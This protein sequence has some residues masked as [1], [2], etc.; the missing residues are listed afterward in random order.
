MN[1]RVAETEPESCLARSGSAASA[2]AAAR[3]R[4]AARH[5]S[6]RVAGREGSRTEP[7]HKDQ[8]VAVN[9]DFS[10]CTVHS[11]KGYDAPVV[12]V[13]SA[14]RFR[15]GARG[16]AAFYVACTRAQQYLEVCTGGQP[17][18]LVDELEHGVERLQS[19][20]EQSK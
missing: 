11:A 18:P 8:F 15:P 17:A 1:P 7:R 3:F 12:I 6:G 19:E 4:D 9:G 5:D 16:R 2:E 10:L 14:D 20:I 13:A